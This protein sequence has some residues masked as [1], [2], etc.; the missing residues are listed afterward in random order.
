MNTHALVVLTNARPGRDDEFND[1]YTNRHLQDVL[2]LDGFVAAQRWELVDT[3]PPQEATYR[4]LAI[5]EV[6]EDQLERA[7]KALAAAS[8]TEVLPRS[9]AM[10]DQRERWWF[11]TI[12]DR[13]TADG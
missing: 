5:Y 6:P 2:A 9:D 13:V 4:Y 11:T 8:G 12:T 1:W 3:S 7:Q 10:A